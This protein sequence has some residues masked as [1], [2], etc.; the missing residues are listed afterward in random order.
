MGPTRVAVKPYTV[1]ACPPT[2]MA[3]VTSVI[4]HSLKP[5]MC[6]A[7]PL[8][9]G[10]V[11]SNCWPPTRASSAGQDEAT[12][13]RPSTSC[14]PGMVPMRSEAP[15]ACRSLRTVH[16]RYSMDCTPSTGLPSTWTALWLAVK[17]VAMAGSSVLH[18]DGRVEEVG[19]T[20][21]SDGDVDPHDALREVLLGRVDVDQE[22]RVGA[23]G[24]R[25]QHSGALHPREGG[26]DLLEQGSP[27][28]GRVELTDEVLRDR[29]DLADRCIG[30][31]GD[32]D[33]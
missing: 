6:S 28:V 7:V 20:D 19:G 25:H 27:G 15:I 5:R 32:G 33:L 18:T 3:K 16:V 8:R 14:C 23:V 26:R 4:W 21:R 24:G 10:T 22:R 2:A 11:S 17:T 12:R 9:S 29:L 31:A 13:I 30:H 1:S